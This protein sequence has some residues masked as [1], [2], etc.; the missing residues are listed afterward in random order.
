MPY[1]QLQVQ[2]HAKQLAALQVVSACVAA[3]AARG[4]QGWQRAM[5]DA[6]DLERRIQGA[7]LLL[8]C[9]EGRGRCAWRI[10][11]VPLL[12]C[13]A[14]WHLCYSGG[15]WGELPGHPG[16]ALQAILLTPS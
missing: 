1:L 7:A 16:H 8:P 6:L 13:S 5:D 11:G 9:S 10:Q 15:R 2:L 12:L 3:G 4:C 14:A